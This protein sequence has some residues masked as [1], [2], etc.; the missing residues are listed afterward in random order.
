MALSSQSVVTILKAAAEPTRLRIL[1]LLAASELNVKDLTRILGQSQP[2]I[3]RHL[4]LLSE[5]G[6]IERTREGSWAYFQLVVAGPSG[7]LARRLLEAVDLADTQLQR[8]RHRAEAVKREREAAAQTYFEEHAAHWDRIRSLHV[9]ENAVEAAM[10]AALGPGPFRNF[11]DAGTG[12]GRVLQLFADRFEHGIG[13]DINHT[14]LAYA[15]STLEGAGVGHARV[16]HG[17]LYDLGLEDGS[18]DAV[19]VHQVLHFLSDPAQAVREAA[20][21]LEPGGRMLIVDFAPHD[22]E[23]LREAH[24]H[25]RLGF[26]PEQVEHWLEESGLKILSTKKLAPEAGDAEGKLTVTLWT[27]ERLRVHAHSRQ[28]ERISRVEV[29]GS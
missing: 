4:K 12:T 10:R 27:A 22:L 20:R 29:V 1:M 28:T 7:A 14:M 17:D 21:V 9:T 13:I 16:R 2:R 8:D 3:S 19:V 18:A 6:L 5:A 24:A 23:F 11:V 26:P 25:E 15:R